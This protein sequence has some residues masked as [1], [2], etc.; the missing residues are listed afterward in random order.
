MPDSVTLTLTLK[1][2]AYIKRA[3][4]R[5]IDECELAEQCG[6]ADDLTAE[7]VARAMSL[8]RLIERVEQEQVYPH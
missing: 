2:L 3:A 5:D 1:E 6:E 7:E 8:L 4:G